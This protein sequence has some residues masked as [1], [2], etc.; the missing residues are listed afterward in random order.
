MPDPTP[1]ILASGI[2]VHCAHRELVDVTTLVPNPRNPTKHPDKQ[3]A[4]LSK[5]IRHQGWRAPITVSNRSGFVV[6][7]HGRLE[8]AKL[9]QVELVPVDRQDFATEA[10]EYAHLIADNRLSELAENDDAALKTLLDELDAGGLDLELAGF[11]AD[12]LAGLVAEPEE[13]VPEENSD[14]KQSDDD[15]SLFELVMLHENK[16]KFIGALNQIKSE[17][18][19]AT[20]EEALMVLVDTYKSSEQES[21]DS[22]T[23]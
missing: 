5:V 10:D 1:P 8:A 14:P 15:Y 21:E 7:G 2:P 11:D 17:R 13:D 3:I 22:P 6:T 18:S 9:L 12:G 4:L 23:S 20:N 19:L 16:L